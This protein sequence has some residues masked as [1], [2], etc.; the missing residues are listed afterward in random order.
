M[1][2]IKEKLLEKMRYHAQQ[3]YP[4]ECCGALIG[5]HGNPG[6]KVLAVMPLD[7]RRRGAAS[8]TRFLVT[9]DDYRHVV[10]EATKRNLDV[11]GFYHSHPD[12]PPCPS[13]FDRE[14]ALPWYAYVIVGVDEGSAGD[15]TCWKLTEDRTRFDPQPI[16]ARH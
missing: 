4:R 15:V 3:E 8:L 6:M 12:H 7:N 14:H 1:I 13:A 9:A 11:L 2:L 16:T 10:K 5:K